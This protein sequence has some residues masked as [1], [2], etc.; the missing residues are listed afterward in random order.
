MRPSVKKSSSARTSRRAC[1]LGHV[2]LAPVADPRLVGIE[3]AERLDH[4]GPAS[5]VSAPWPA[6]CRSSPSAL[7]VSIAFECALGL[8]HAAMEACT[9]HRFTR[10]SAPAHPQ[11]RGPSAREAATGNRGRTRLQR[12]PVE[13]H[14]ETPGCLSAERRSP[15]SLVPR[16]TCPFPQRAR[17]APPGDRG[18]SAWRDRRVARQAGDAFRRPAPCR[19][20]RKMRPRWPKCPWQRIRLHGANRTSMRPCRCAFGDRWNRSR[21]YAYAA[22]TDLMVAS[23]G[24]S[25]A[26]RLT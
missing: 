12:G 8:L 10:I 22:R 13:Q 6:A 1:L 26:S 9:H 20:A 5:R 21:K 18:H 24:S 19:F 14:L 17:R 15:S 25:R 16:R 4:T 11:P 7:D 3:A 2:A 23:L